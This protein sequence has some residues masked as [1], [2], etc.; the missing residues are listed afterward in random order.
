[1]LCYIFK[2]ITIYVSVYIKEDILSE[3]EKL[4]LISEFHDRPLGGYKG[5][6]R[7]FNRIHVQFYWKGMRKQ[8]RD[9]IKKCPICQKNKIGN[10]PLKEPM[11]ITITSSRPFEKI[12]LDVVGP[13]PRSHKGNSFVLTLLDNL[14]KFAWAVSM[15]NHEANTVAHHFVTQFVFR[16]FTWST[17]EPCNR[18]WYRVSQQSFQ[19]NLQPS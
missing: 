5:V 16:V 2:N 18:L 13:L 12:F 9:F 14:T 17:T 11:I 4:R 15:E 7:T 3:D 19:G 8:I 1:M 6:T 10:K